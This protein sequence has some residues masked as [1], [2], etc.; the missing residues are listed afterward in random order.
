MEF[1]DAAEEEIRENI[2]NTVK[3]TAREDFGD[4]AGGLSGDSGTGPDEDF[5]FLN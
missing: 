1:A 3:D 4:M 2:D 5:D